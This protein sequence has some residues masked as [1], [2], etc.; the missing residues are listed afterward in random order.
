MMKI[1]T[2]IILSIF[3][4]SCNKN[5]GNLDQTISS[6]VTYRYLNEEINPYKFKLGS[7]WIFENDTTGALDSIAVLYIENDFYWSTPALNGNAG[8]KTEY[9]KINLKSFYANKSFNDFLTHNFIKRNGGGE[10]GT[11]GQPIFIANSAIGTVFNGMEIMPKISALPISGHIFNAVDVVK[12]NASNQIQVE[13]TNDTYLYYSDSIG[14][15]K[16]VTYLANT[17]DSWSLKR[18]HVIK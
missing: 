16:K 1:I 5:K 17:I 14:L 8:T 10:Y 4:L 3:F 9:Y 2:L 15:I 7:Y 12:I 11:F 6:E 18:C 13:F